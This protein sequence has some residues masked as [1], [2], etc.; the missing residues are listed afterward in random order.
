M[1][2]GSIVSAAVG[3][4]VSAASLNAQTTNP[5]PAAPSDALLKKAGIRPIGDWQVDPVE[6]AELNQIFA[7]ALKA[8]NS[9]P[10]G[11]DSGAQRHAVNNELRAELENFL[12]EHPGSA[13]GP[14][15]HV[16]LGK[17][18]RSVCGY[19]L[20]M[21]H[22]QSAFDTASGSPDPTAISIAL[23]AGAGLSK[24][25]ALTGQIVEL[26]ALEARALQIRAG[27]PLWGDWK[28][29]RELRAWVLKHPT[30]AYKCGL[31]CLDQLGRLTQPGQFL[32]KNITETDF[33]TN[34]YTAADLLSIAG[35][36]GLRIHAAAFTDTN[37]IPVPCILHLRSQH[38]VLVREQRGAFYEVID[39]VAYG[40]RWLTAPDI[41]AEAT[42]CVL[43]SDAV[44]PAH[45]ATLVP[46]DPVAAA[47]YRGRCHTP[48][49]TD[50]NDNGPCTSCS[51]CPPGA[52]GGDP[53]GPGG[54]GSPGSPGGPG[55]PPGRGGPGP[56][57]SSPVHGGPVRETRA[58]QQPQPIAYSSCPTCSGMPTWLV[59]E[60]Y[61]NLWLID[62]PMAYTPAYGPAVDLTLARCERPQQDAFVLY[63]WHGAR[64]GDD[65]GRWSCSW[66]SFA[67]L[68]SDGYEVDL[69]L[70]AGGWALF[71]FTNS[72]TVST[73][74][75]QQNL[76]LE[77]QGPS[78]GSSPA[79][80]TNL[81]LHYPDGSQTS[82]GVE[83]TNFSNITGVF[84]MTAKTDP[85]GVSAT[86]AYDANYYL[87]KVTA[88]D[89]AYFT[90]SF[91]DAFYA[92]YVTAVTNS[93]G[94]S[95]ELAYDSR[96]HIH[97]TNITDTAGIS[98]IIDYVDQNG[99][100]GDLVTPYGTTLFYNNDNSFGGASQGV[101]DRF[102][103]ITNATGTI[104]FYGQINGYTN[105]DWTNFAS[106]QIPTNTP[107]GT[108]DKDSG[109]RQERNTFY[110][111]AQQ[112]TPYVGTSL[113]SF[114]WPIF[115]QGRIRH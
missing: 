20:A 28:A 64:L 66:L 76:W 34:G 48:V 9:I 96:Y 57:R 32:P 22:F 6:T 107:V 63:Y 113:A 112:F 82:Y 83:D 35:S 30:E 43:V 109:Q 15:L 74:N 23:D 115:M 3:C 5:P 62:Q 84:Y 31:Y 55:G 40:P 86:F 18:A 39:L 100:P 42:G 75:Y 36:A 53:G 1:K 94:T 114:N 24:L 51:T 65:A 27:R 90:L 91:N 88:A 8:A 17:E 11:P 52:G 59:S 58:P 21:E 103:E 98:S 25:L 81:V 111:N 80:V 78:A 87:Q 14:G 7:S 46:I 71:A 85:M 99:D 10:I 29:A 69:M 16:L 93:Y 68:S 49:P 110:W 41:V 97:L 92:D 101:F 13:Y 37:S 106:A 95:V 104:E 61:L 54:P 50:H 105:T 45:S 47:G 102:E 2:Y 38:F 89:G 12:T 70:P 79:G 4:L 67:E 73:V 19:S 33:S 56:N 77:K 108:L 26:D 72:S 60:P 44:P